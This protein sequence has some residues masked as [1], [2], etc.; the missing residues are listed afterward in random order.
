MT[1][2]WS[3]FGVFLVLFHGVEAVEEKEVQENADVTLKCDSQ[4]ASVYWLR[5]KE[6][7]QDFEYMATY[8]SSKKFRS[9][10][11]NKFKMTE[12]TLKVIGFKQQEDSGTYS[13]IFINDNELRFSG[14]T[15]LRGVKVPTTTIK[16][17]VQTTRL[18]TVA[19]MTTTACR[20][21]PNGGKKAAD[22]S[23]AVLLGCELHIF[24]SLAASCGLLL[25]FLLATIL[26]CNHIRT[27]RCPHHYKRQPRSRP[28]GHK[29]LPNPMDY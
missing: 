17:K 1:L 16:P 22:K 6:N 5:M 9:S 14:T 3:V 8:T 28:A 2:I 21:N 18:P 26:Y 23:L 4:G 24:I 13:C 19:V 27:R 10:D 15:K 29:T 7:K 20:Q 12:Q 11:K 25:L